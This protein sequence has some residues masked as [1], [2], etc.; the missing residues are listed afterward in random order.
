MLLDTIQ[1]AL[2][3]LSVFLYRQKIKAI[4]VQTRQLC[5]RYA[6]VIN[7]A[8]TI[9][10][11]INSASHTHTNTTHALCVVQHRCVVCARVLVALCARILTETQRRRRLSIRRRPRLRSTGRGV[12]RC[13]SFHTHNACNTNKHADCIQT[14]RCRRRRRCLRSPNTITLT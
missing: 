2:K 6:A 3:P 13:A 14:R 7:D 10:T 1:S 12:V 9:K 4:T 8:T 5:A 11:L